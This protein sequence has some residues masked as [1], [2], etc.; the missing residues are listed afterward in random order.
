MTKQKT[1]EGYFSYLLIKDSST[2]VSAARPKRKAAEVYVWFF[3]CI[4]AIRST[5]GGKLIPR[6]SL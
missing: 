6:L 1:V 5:L 4:C 3:T 2:E